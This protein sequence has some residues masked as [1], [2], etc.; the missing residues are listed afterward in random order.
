M[1]AD[2]RQRRPVVSYNTL[3][4]QIK[5]T[6]MSTDPGGVCKWG[7]SRPTT[8]VPPKLQ[9]IASDPDHGNGRPTR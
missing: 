4:R 3:P 5:T 9:A 2:L 6:D 1:E 8:D 7:A